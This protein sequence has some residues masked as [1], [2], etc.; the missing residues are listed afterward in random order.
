MPQ[1][2]NY[3]IGIQTFEQIIE[4]DY[5]YVDKTE[6]IHKLATTN[7]CVFLSRPRRF[8]KSLLVSTL[9]AYFQGRKALF[10]GLAI[11]TL[12]KEWKA[13]P[14]LRFDLSGENYDC[15]EKLIEKISLTL[16][17]YED[18]YGENPKA[19]SIA[20]RFASLLANAE[21]QTTQKVVILIDEYDKPL[22][23]TLH[24]DPL[25]EDL[26]NELAAFYGVM[27]GKDDAIR[28]VLLTG[29]T[30]F[31]HVSVFSGL[32]NLIDIS[33]DE[34]YNAI[35]GVSET[36]FRKYFPESVKSLAK[37]YNASEEDMWNALRIHYDG[38]HFSKSKEGIY[39][40]F[41]LMVSFKRRKLGFFWF[42]SGTPWFLVNTLN[43]YGFPLSSLEGEWF[44][45]EE[46]LDITDPEH[47]YQALFFQAGYLTIKGYQPGQ[48]VPF[49]KLEKFQL[50]FPNEEVRYGFWNTLYDKYL[51]RH[52]PRSIF[53][54]PEFIKAVETGNPQ[55][56][57]ERLQS[58]LAE[59]SHGNT[60]KD[61]VRL[62]EINFQNDLQ[63]I[64]R[65]LGF[66][67]HTEITTASGR[68]DMTVETPSFVYLF[69]FKTDST[70]ESALKQIKDNGYALKFKADPRRVFLIGANFDPTTN[71]LDSFLIE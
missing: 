24:N 62:K 69:E 66:E 18:I 21:K 54:Q 15:P 10:K 71:S 47:N 29:I 68:I 61:N 11:E 35:C 36:E 60:P 19:K 17:H 23:D 64:F 50:G 9:E 25:R 20:A 59:L 43:C 3:P 1:E 52:H 63:I 7:K 41:S 53:N 40:P 44:T 22:T 27:K 31:G 34:D 2:I 39:N 4:G 70:P 26:R 8:G 16:S 49:V 33:L 5:V 12:E 14:V 37:E 45:E 67:V 42:T 13:Y 6:L 48:I 51:F 46:L 32:N 28:F 65:M 57:M 55:E 58:L 30:K 56:F 38:Y